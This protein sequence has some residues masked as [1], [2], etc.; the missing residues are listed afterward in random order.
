MKK[1]RLSQLT[2]RQQSLLKKAREAIRNEPQSYEQGTYGYGHVDCRTPGCIAAH[3]VANDAGLRHE[4]GEA[5]R[6]IKDSP[7]DGTQAEAIQSAID[8]IATRGLDTKGTPKLFAST[9]A[10]AWR[11]TSSEDPETDDTEGRFLPEAD[12]AVRV[13]DAVLEGRIRDALEPERR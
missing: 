13:L 5:I 12:D 2:R 1:R 10:S 11:E 3:I 9:W 8:R 4:L 7:P 6:D